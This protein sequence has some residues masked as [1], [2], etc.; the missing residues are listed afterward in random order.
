[1]GCALE[2]RVRNTL[3][4]AGLIISQSQVSEIWHYCNWE[5]SC[6][7]KTPDDCVGL[8]FLPSG[9]CIPLKPGRELFIIN[10][11]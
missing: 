6:S 7:G 1:M 8:F 5:T 3:T 4:V 2:M 11:R 9:V 10:G